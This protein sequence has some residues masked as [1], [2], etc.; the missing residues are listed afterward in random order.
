MRYV[1][2]AKRFAVRGADPPHRVHLPHPLP[3]AFHPTRTPP[4]MRRRPVLPATLLAVSL[5]AGGCAALFGPS[6]EGERFERLRGGPSGRPFG[7]GVSDAGEVLS[8]TGSKEIVLEDLQVKGKVW[9]DGASSVTL[10]KCRFEILEL[11]IPDSG[12]TLTGVTV[13]KSFKT[14]GDRTKL[15]AENC[16]LPN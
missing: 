5:L 15:K 4:P 11:A 12:A 14:T 6:F 8:L 2:G 1:N 3:G 13:D 16:K 10:S 7:L 9:I